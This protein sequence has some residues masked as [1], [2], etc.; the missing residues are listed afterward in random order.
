MPL[1]KGT[2]YFFKKIALKVSQ[3]AVSAVCRPSCGSRL[4][5]KLKSAC[6]L[7]F[8][9]PA[10]KAALKSFPAQRLF[11]ELG[12]QH[13]HSCS[14]CARPAGCHD[15]TGL[16]V[17]RIQAPSYF[18]PFLALKAERGQSCFAMKSVEAEKLGGQQHLKEN[19]NKSSLLQPLL[20]GYEAFYFQFTM[21]ALSAREDL[22]AF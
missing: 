22:A 1:Q 14:C 3:P 5:T 2:K 21:E 13:T 9:L 10:Q 17:R 20:A 16:V 6:F 11:L 8:Q 19:P 18:S 15:A 4:R 7:C 12:K